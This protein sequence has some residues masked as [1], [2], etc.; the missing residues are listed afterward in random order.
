M[1]SERAKF[2]LALHTAGRLRRLLLSFILGER[3][4]MSTK[5]KYQIEEMNIILENFK[6][7]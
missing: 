6:Q 4:A 7:I 1:K 3:S 5:A 2:M